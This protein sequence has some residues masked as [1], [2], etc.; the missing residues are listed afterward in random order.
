MLD[1]FPVHLLL[2]FE[3]YEIHHGNG[4]KPSRRQTKLLGPHV[5]MT[6]RARTAAS[7][8]AMICRLTV[9][10]IVVQWHPA[11]PISTSKE[12]AMID[13]DMEQYV[14]EHEGG[15]GAWTTF[16][17][18]HFILYVVVAAVPGICHRR[19]RTPWGVRAAE[20]LES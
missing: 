7:E 11:C 19:Y 14:R 18:Q 9:I 3:I 4:R 13:S 2:Q 6:N 12:Y 15:C 20:L 8:T 1:L 17:K 10:S 16:A 5:C